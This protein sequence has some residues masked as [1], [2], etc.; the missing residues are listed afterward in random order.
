MK[1][2]IRDLL[3]THVTEIKYTYLLT[4]PYKEFHKAEFSDASMLPVASALHL[5]ISS[6]ILPLEAS[7]AC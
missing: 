4:I 3:F 7:D 6:T 5:I 1:Y 2:V